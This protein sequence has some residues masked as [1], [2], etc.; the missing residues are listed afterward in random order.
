MDQR[1]G[2]AAAQ[3]V[4]HQVQR[5]RPSRVH[6]RQDAD[7]RFRTWPLRSSLPTMPAT[8]NRYLSILRRIGNLAEEWGLVDHPPRIKLLTEHNQRHVY[9]TPQEVAR[10]A[11]KCGPVV[12]DFVR[13]LALTGLRRGELLGLTPNQIRNESILLD[14]RTKTGKARRIP[15]GPEALRIAQARLPWKLTVWDIRREFGAARKAARLPQVRLHD[16]GI[17]SRVS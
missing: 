9:L 12:G 5:R 15:L 8:I 3:L 14:A 13:L 7:A 17:R 10:L 2:Q 1:A 6:Q 16:C 11:G 4:P